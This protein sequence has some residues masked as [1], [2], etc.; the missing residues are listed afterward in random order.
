MFMCSEGVCCVPILNSAVSGKSSRRK[1][2]FGS[3][4]K[5][6]N[7]LVRKYGKCLFFL[8]LE[9]FL[10]HF[11]TMMLTSK[12]GRRGKDPWRSYGDERLRGV[13]KFIFFLTRHF[14]PIL[15]GTL[16]PPGAKITLVILFPPIF[17]TRGKILQPPSFSSGIFPMIIASIF[18]FFSSSSSDWDSDSHS[19]IFPPPPIIFLSASSGPLYV[20][21]HLPS[22][23]PALKDNDFYRPLSPSLSLTHTRRFPTFKSRQGCLFGEGVGGGGGGGGEEGQGKTAR[24]NRYTPN[25]IKTKK[26][27][28]FDCHR[29][30][31]GQ[32]WRKSA[33]IAISWTFQKKKYFFHS[34]VEERT[35]GQPRSTMRKKTFPLLVRSTDSLIFFPQR[36]ETRRIGG[37]G[38]N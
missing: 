24:G 7:Y 17:T 35:S 14:P 15:K 6:G 3:G 28:F 37:V 16:E 11:G 23:P 36:K 32:M 21:H 26:N 22:F 34:I 19:H 27:A 30:H 29:T 4:Q 33:P 8:L 31:V 20:I 10:S 9:S 13:S 1:D 25:E 5:K 38:P 2:I 18:P 12:K